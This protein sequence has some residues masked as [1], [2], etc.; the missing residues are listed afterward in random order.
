MEVKL[1]NKRPLYYIYLY[2][3]TK[4]ESQLVAKFTSLKDAIAFMNM[5]YAN[6]AGRNITALHLVFEY[7]GN[8]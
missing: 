6:V 8:K 3:Y 2:S 5:R 1:K 4:D 7:L